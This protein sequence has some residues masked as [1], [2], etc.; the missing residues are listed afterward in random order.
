MIVGDLRLTADSGAPKATGGALVECVISAAFHVAG[1]VQPSYPL[2][3]ELQLAMQSFV[4]YLIPHSDPPCFKIP[5]GD[6]QPAVLVTTDPR[7]FKLFDGH[8]FLLNPKGLIIG[9]GLLQS[10]PSLPDAVAVCGLLIAGVSAAW[11]VA[12]SWTTGAT[13]SSRRMLWVRRGSALWLGALAI[14]LLARGLSA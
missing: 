7:A 10:A 3:A 13:D 5:Q 1:A 2:Y 6:G 9:L 8:G 4:E 14:V 11:A 12:G